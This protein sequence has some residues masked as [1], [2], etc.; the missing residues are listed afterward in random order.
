MSET[1]AYLHSYC[2]V[3]QFA[4]CG[5]RVISL[6]CRRGGGIM[7]HLERFWRCLKGWLSIFKVG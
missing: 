1:H 3:G 7:V 4:I 5:P 2:P 6:F